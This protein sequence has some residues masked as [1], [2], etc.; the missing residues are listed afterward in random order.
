MQVERLES[1]LC[2]G[3]THLAM[4]AGRQIILGFLLLL[5]CGLNRGKRWRINPWLASSVCQRFACII[6]LVLSHFFSF[7]L[8]KQFVDIF[9]YYQLCSL[10]QKLSCLTISVL[11]QFNM[12][13][14]I[15]FARGSPTT[16]PVC[17]HS[18]VVEEYS[19]GIVYSCLYLRNTRSLFFLIFSHRSYFSH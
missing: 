2:L 6:V 8:Q 9:Q 11:L 7:F 13:L 4:I 15:S 14:F 1:L 19:V 16:V 12:A 18:R 17:T 10:A 5:A 3:T